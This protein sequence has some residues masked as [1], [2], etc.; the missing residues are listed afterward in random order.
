MKMLLGNKK[1][2]K[3]QSHSPHCPAWQNLLYI[4]LGVLMVSDCVQG[5]GLQVE[6]MKLFGDSFDFA[7]VLFLGQNHQHLINSSMHHLQK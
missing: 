3:K 5:H 7:L 4:Y 6:M 2:K 1:K